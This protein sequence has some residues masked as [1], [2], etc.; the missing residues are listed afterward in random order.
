MMN[1]ECLGEMRL[2]VTFT[3]FVII[4]IFGVFET[5]AGR[6]TATVKK[7]V[8]RVSASENRQTTGEKR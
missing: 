4:G 8:E 1:D 7:E 5:C 6:I 3:R 2:V